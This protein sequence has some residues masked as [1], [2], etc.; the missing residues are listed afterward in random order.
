MKLQTEVSFEAAANKFHMDDS[1]LVL[2]SCFSGCV[3]DRL[4]ALGMNVL[5]NPFGPLY[6]AASMRSA[7]ERIVSGEHFTQEDCVSLGAGSSRICSF[8]HH[9]LAS[10]TDAESF[11]QDANAVLDEAHAFW[12]NCNKIILTLGSSWCYRHIERDMIVSNCLKRDA[13]EFRREFLSLEQIEEQLQCMYALACASG[14]KRD[15]LVSVSPIR[16]FKDGAHGN[17]LS[18]ANLLLASDRLVQEH[19][20]VEY[21]P[22]Y[23]I[24]MDELRDYRFYA[25]DMLHPSAQSENYIFERFIEW[26]FS[27]ADRAELARRQQAL[28]RSLHISKMQ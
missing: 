18:K 26:G 2:G 21:F 4:Q 14:K 22:A 15:I 9:T 28:K 13:C 6:N 19:D 24:M 25:E 27:P 7:L 23:E 1:I 16:H 10:R 11:L 8:H 12:Q 3:G 20:N 17:M 5:V